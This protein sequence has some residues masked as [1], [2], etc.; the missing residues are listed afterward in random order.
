M[1]RFYTVAS[2]SHQKFVKFRA[3]VTPW[4]VSPRGWYHQLESTP[5]PPHTAPLCEVSGSICCQY[6]IGVQFI[7]FTKCFYQRYIE[8]LVIT[9]LYMALQLWGEKKGGDTWATFGSSQLAAQAMR[10]DIQ[11]TTLQSSIIPQSH[12]LYLYVFHDLKKTD[13]FNVWIILKLYP[14]EYIF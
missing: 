7:L 9:P 2:P 5:I 14:Y 10:L 6:I 3:G 11:S 13:I 8:A 12:V 4:M 1:L